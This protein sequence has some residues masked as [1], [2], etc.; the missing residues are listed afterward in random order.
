M[1]LSRL[2]RFL[3][4]TALLLGLLTPAMNASQ[5]QHFKVA[6]YIRAYEV[7]RMKDPEWLRSQWAIVEGQV[8]V[9][10]VY[11]ETHRDLIIIDDETLHAV[12]AFFA[13]KGIE[14][15]GGIATVRNER[16]L[17]EVFC[18]TQQ[19]HR[20]KIREIVTAT[21]RNFDEFIID[22][23]FFTTCSCD[24]CLAAKGERSWSRYRLDLMTEVSRNLVLATARSVNPGVRVI[25][26]YPNWYEHFH[27]SGYNLETQ[28]PLFDG[29]YTGTETRDPATTGQHLQQYH[30][31]SI[32]RYLEN[33]SP[34]R[35]GGGWVDTGARGQADRYAEQLWITLFGKAREITLFAFHEL[36][37]PYRNSDRAAWQGQGTSFDYDRAVAS[38]PK[39]ITPTLASTAGQSLASADALVGALGNPIGMAAYRPF[40]STGDDFLHSYLGNAGIPV[41]LEPSY[42]AQAP[43]IFLAESAK[44][45]ADILAKIGRSLREGRTVAITAGLLAALQ[46]RGLG[47]IAEIGCNGRTVL[48]ESFGS[49][50]FSEAVPQP[51]LLPQ[52]QYLTNEAWDILSARSGPQGFPLVLSQAYGK[53]RL[54][55]IAIPENPADLY[56]IPP[57]TLSRLRE[58]LSAGLPVRLEGPSLVSL[59]LYDNGTLIVESFRDEPVEITLVCPPG[60]KSLQGLA[61]TT[62]LAPTASDD[63]ATRFTLT[64]PPHSFR[65]YQRRQ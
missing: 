11:I 61:G 65:G 1:S 6:V 26:K 15:A 49:W 37:E 30:S 7:L 40:H 14:T 10:K 28:P 59:F 45:D 13:A 33:I 5:Y 41:E 24:E 35:N 2:L 34:G 25:L 42:P 27:G 60:T 50:G 12:K 4:P 55:V 32:M 8:K 56:R 52:V 16:N 47:D 46:E 62:P 53:G 64:V 21:A 44:A 31:Y 22:D 3:L 51:I 43:L 63:K 19:S 54:L 58:F 29:I 20:D 36:L 17:F 39:G 38:V 18:Y 57:H 48:A 9:D 23:F